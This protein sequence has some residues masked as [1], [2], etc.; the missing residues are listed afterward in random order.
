MIEEMS[1]SV[2]HSTLDVKYQIEL[3][4]DNCEVQY[5]QI[6]DITAGDAPVLFD[7]HL[8]ASVEQYIR[9]QYESN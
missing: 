1:V 4:S 7:E 9:D 2:S 5:L 8:W 6:I 3:D